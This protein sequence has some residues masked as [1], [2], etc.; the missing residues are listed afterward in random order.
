[1][2]A[3]VIVDDPWLQWLY[4]VIVIIVLWFWYQT[5]SRCIVHALGYEKGGGLL[6]SRVMQMRLVLTPLQPRLMARRVPG[7]RTDNSM[8]EMQHRK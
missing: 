2:D 4:V 8:I 5:S 6:T 3:G 1:M 7:D